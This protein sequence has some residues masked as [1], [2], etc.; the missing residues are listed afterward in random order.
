MMK[1]LVSLLGVTGMLVQA[2]PLENNYTINNQTPFHMLIVFN[3]IDLGFANYQ[4]A[5]GSVTYLAPNSSSTVNTGGTC[6]S[7]YWFITGTT[8]MFEPTIIGAT[9]AQAP[10]ACV[11]ESVPAAKMFLSTLG[12]SSPVFGG[13]RIPVSLVGVSGESNLS[14]QGNVLLLDGKTY[15]AFSG[16]GCANRNITLQY[17]GAWNAITVSNEYGARSVINHDYVANNY[18]S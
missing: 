15:Q 12:L 4:N 7:G 17:D 2:A 8:G 5:I 13:K 6:S 3:E 14:P 9:A 11:I 10:Q 18:L 1:L 16:D